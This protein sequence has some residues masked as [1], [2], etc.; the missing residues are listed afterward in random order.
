MSHSTLMFMFSV[1]LCWTVS[2]Q[3]LNRPC[4]VI[5]NY[6]GKEPS[7]HNTN[8]S[9]VTGPVDVSPHELAWFGV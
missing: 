4:I 5:L 7:E 9:N 1:L 3:Q 2:S 8:D 6:A